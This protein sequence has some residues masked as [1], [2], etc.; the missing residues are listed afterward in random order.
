MQANYKRNNHMHVLRLDH[1][2]SLPENSGICAAQSTK[3]NGNIRLTL[4]G[5]YD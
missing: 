3:T 1:I 4:S 2:G 5:D